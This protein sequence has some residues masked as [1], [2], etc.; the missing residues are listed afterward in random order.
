MLSQRNKTSPSR[1]ETVLW[2]VEDMYNLWDRTTV[3][4]YVRLKLID[5]PI[6]SCLVGTVTIGGASVLAPNFN[7]ALRA[8]DRMTIKPTVV[9]NRSWK[10]LEISST[11]QE[12]PTYL[13]ALQV[14]A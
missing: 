6:Y 2:F 10:S 5:N 14:Q 1:I 11:S 7:S 13:V 12:S 8:Q 3:V 9:Q 4:K